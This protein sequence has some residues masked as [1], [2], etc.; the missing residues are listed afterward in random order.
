MMT[1]EYNP[2]PVWVYAA[3][4]VLAAAAVAAL[5]TGVVRKVRAGRPVAGAAIGAGVLAGGAALVWLVGA[6]TVGIQRG[7]LIEQAALVYGVTVDPADRPLS[8]GTPMI[9][10]GFA[11]CNLDRHDRERVGGGDDFFISCD[12]TDLRDVLEEGRAAW[13]RDAAAGAAS[14][15]AGDLPLGA[16]NP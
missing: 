11:I 12:G 14:G 6:T 1:L 2:T 13:D 5:I 3:A 10:N 8:V 9:V 16:A 4:G 7:M 15:F